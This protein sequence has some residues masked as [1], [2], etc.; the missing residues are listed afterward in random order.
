MAVEQEIK[1]KELLINKIKDEIAEL[2]RSITCDVEIGKWYK[3]KKYGNF[4]CK[5]TKFYDDAIEVISVG[6]EDGELSYL[7]TYDVY[8]TMMLKSYELEKVS[9]EEV[10][11]EIT[12][13]NNKVLQEHR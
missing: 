12:R 13:H 4:F 10:I 8:T 1:E 7:D 5:P 6:I 2:K 3:S 11:K 9:Y